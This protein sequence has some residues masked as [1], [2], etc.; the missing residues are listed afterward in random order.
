MYPVL[1]YTFY[2]NYA[3]IQSPWSFYM[4]RFP[5]LLLKEVLELQGGSTAAKI[6]FPIIT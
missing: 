5:F 2:H 3:C 4:V 6:S 1:R